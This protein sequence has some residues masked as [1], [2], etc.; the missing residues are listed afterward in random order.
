MY[1]RYTLLVLL[2][3]RRGMNHD[4][5]AAEKETQAHKYCY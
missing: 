4:I 5:E 2:S 1:V 3:V